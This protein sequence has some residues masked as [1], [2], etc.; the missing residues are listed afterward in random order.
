MIGGKNISYGLVRALQ[1]ILNINVI[2]DLEEDDWGSDNKRGAEENPVADKFLLVRELARIK[3][4][5]D[6]RAAGLDTLVEPDVVGGAT[7]RVGE[8]A[9]EPI[10][11][12]Y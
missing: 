4:V 3:I 6:S 8:S 10:H 7:T 9:H 2:P 11:I 5:H 12:D 1:I